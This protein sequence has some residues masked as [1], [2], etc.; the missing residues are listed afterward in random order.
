MESGTID[1]SKSRAGRTRSG[2]LEPAVRPLAANL[3]VCNHRD[4][5]LARRGG[6]HPDRRPVMVAVLLGLCVFWWTGYRAR[7]Q[8]H[9][10]CPPA[11]Q[12]L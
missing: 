7:K 4:A 8:N 12:F 2:V 1:Y 6:C 3:S 11:T 5:F 9:K 10:A